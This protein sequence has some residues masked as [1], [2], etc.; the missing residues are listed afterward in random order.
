MDLI[1]S[2]ELRDRLGANGWAHVKSKFHYE[3]L[4]KDMSNL[5]TSLLNP[6]L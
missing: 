6:E 1:E 2:K 5:Y 4:A 3:R